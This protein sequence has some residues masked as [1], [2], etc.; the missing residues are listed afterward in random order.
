MY[1][2]RK[3]CNGNSSYFTYAIICYMQAGV[4]IQVSRFS[5]VQI[6]Q[7]KGDRVKILYALAREISIPWSPF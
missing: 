7:I 4:V 1:V 2:L 3:N 6:P 5:H